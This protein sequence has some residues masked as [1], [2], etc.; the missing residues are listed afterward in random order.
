MK[1]ELGFTL[2]EL[3]LTVSLMTILLVGSLGSISRSKQNEDLLSTVMKIVQFLQLAQER[4]ITGAKDSSWKIILSESLVRLTDDAGNG[5]EFYQLPAGQKLQTGGV[6]EIGFIRPGGW[7]QECPNS[8]D[9]AVEINGSN[10]R[11][12]FRVLPSGVVEY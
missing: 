10:S 11:Y 2:L 1:D 7:A 9:F 4:S 5:Q 12:Q 3:I 8:C 6:G